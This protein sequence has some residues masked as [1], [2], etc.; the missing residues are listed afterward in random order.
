MFKTHSILL[1]TVIALE[2]AACG[3]KPADS[4]DTTGTSSGPGTSSNGMSTTTLPTTTVDPTTS[5]GST[6]TSTTDGHTT[7]T[8]T[9]ETTVSVDES[10]TTDATT[11]EE[12]TT[13]CM[14]LPLPETSTD[15]G[16]TDPSTGGQCEDPPD[17]PQN[18]SCT[19]AS[20]C[21]C[22]SGKCFLIPILGGLCGEC[23]DDDDCPGG[24]TIPNPIASIGATCNLGG[25]GAGCN[26]DATCLN[27]CAAKCGAVLDVPGIITVST[28]GTC[29]TNAD[30]TSPARPNCTPS[31]DVLNFTG[32][33][34]CKPDG[35]V[36]NNEGCSLTDD[37]MGEPLGNHVCQSGKCGQASVMGILNLGICG[38]CNADADC[39][40]GQT[41]TDPQVDLNSGALIGSVCM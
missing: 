6:S 38:E 3:D 10:G 12:G 25:P 15:P 16:T 29:K 21:G 41:C 13:E 32:G 19:D 24:C 8:A 31:Y 34:S 37:G 40:N 11:G 18:S 27:T 7:T 20:G 28:C 1:C 26:T 17:Q 2:L 4:A 22:A 36:A 23:L 39:P 9:A 30:C 14:E 5:A 35:S 33:L